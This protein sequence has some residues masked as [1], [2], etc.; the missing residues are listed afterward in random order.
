MP[1]AGCRMP[2]NAL[3]NIRHLN[4]TNQHWDREINH[5]EHGDHG[6]IDGLDFP[7]FP[8]V[9]RGLNCPNLSWSDLASGIFFRHLHLPKF[10]SDNTE[11][12]LS[13]GQ[14]YRPHE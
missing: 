14:D 5:G 10:L 4:Q 7:L 3:S 6:E 12:R 13:D 8:R 9:P 1:D 11:E 2:G